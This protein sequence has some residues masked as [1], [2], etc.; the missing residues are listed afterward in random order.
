MSISDTILLN[1]IRPQPTNV[2]PVLRKEK[3]VSI[4]KVTTDIWDLFKCLKGVGLTGL[5]SEPIDV[6]HIMW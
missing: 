4:E 3:L 5:M 1:A 6:S 2:L